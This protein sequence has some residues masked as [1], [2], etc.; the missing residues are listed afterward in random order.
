MLVLEMF[1]NLCFFDTAYMCMFL[2]FLLTKTEFLKLIVTTTF[3]NENCA[4]FFFKDEWRM[5]VFLR[6]LLPSI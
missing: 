3:L 2:Y 4:C 1:K 6:D 5:L